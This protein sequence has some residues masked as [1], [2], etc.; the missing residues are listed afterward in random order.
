L[1]FS[2]SWTF[3]ILKVSFAIKPILLGWLML[4]LFQTVEALLR[5]ANPTKNMPISRLT[6]P[7]I[8]AMAA[9]WVALIPDLVD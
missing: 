9:K 1:G 5:W 8:F 7:T 3:T 4:V 2:D 6:Q